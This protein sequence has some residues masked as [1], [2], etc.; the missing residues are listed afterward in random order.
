MPR[1]NLPTPRE[2]MNIGDYMPQ[3]NPLPFL[4]EVYTLPVTVGG[5]VNREVRNLGNNI[6]KVTP[7]NHTTDELTLELLMLAD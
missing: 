5:H 1:M 3:M 7:I 6:N 4:K 2:M